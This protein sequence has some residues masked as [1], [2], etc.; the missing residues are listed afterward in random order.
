MNILH[1]KY[2][3]EVARAGSINKA[4]QIL[5][6]SQPN[7]SRAIKEME[8]D[9]GITIFDRSAKG[10]V[11]TPEGEEFV[12][13]AEHILN[14]ID[15]VESHYKNGTR[16]KQ[17]FSISGPR[18]S[19]ISDAFIRF[20]KSIGDAPAEILYRETT[21]SQAI[22]N[23]VSNDYRLGIIRYAEHYDRHFKNLLDEK[24]LAWEPVREFHYYIVMHKD[25]PL[26]EKEKIYFSDIERQIEIIHADPGETLLPP[27]KV[28]K[29]IGKE[30]TARR[31]YVFERAS[32]F[33]L[34][35]E[36]RETLMWMSPVPAKILK[37]YELVQRDC[38]DNKN[39]IYKDLLI[40]RKN[41][42][43]TDLDVKFIDELHRFER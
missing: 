16:K 27:T 32:R 6:T 10:M 43:F 31:I 1:M 5:L 39:V 25:S 22:D 8:A 24:G 4:A 2:A 9:L 26:A 12:G 38:E 29:E 34:L 11:L 15:N 23:I 3:V 30:D 37:R 14:Q 13:Y 18:A 21:S 40:Y 36:N 20:S 7:L 42:R 28:K 19:Y 35:S 33:D 41:Y 17:H